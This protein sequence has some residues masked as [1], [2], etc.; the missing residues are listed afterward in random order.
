MDGPTDDVRALA[1]RA[2][3]GDPAAWETVYRRS[4]ARLF[5]YALRR[6]GSEHAADDAVS[7]TMLR[8]LN[9]I[10]TF[11]W[12]G[13]GF[14]AWLYGILRN[15]VLESHRDRRRMRSLADVPEQPVSD[16]TLEL[17]V[18]DDEVAELLAAFDCL[19]PDEQEMLEL[20]VVADLSADDVG[21]ILGRR[22]GAVRMAQSRALARLRVLYQGS[23]HA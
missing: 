13:A 11:T 4:Y 22:P 3:T 8:A 16:H 7:E 21:E 2:A 10:E 15:V 19:T 1:A 9:R 6:L 12:R 23:S 17:L 20:R 5:A 14:D 18:K